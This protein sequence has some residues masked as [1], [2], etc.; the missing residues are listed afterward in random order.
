MTGTRDIELRVIVSIGL[1]AVN[2]GQTVLIESIEESA[3]AP[4]VKLPSMI[5]YFVQ[6][7][8]TLWDIAKRFKTTPDAII[9]N[10]GSEK[11]LLKSGKQIYIFR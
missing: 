3:D 6:D 2:P 4:C 5:I 7:G 8:D 9:S 10:N 11:D 1:K